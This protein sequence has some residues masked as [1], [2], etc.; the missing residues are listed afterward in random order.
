MHIMQNDSVPKNLY[1][2]TGLVA[3]GKDEAQLNDFVTVV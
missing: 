1:Y 2:I 3:A